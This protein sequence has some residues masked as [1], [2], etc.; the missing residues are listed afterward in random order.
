MRLLITTDTVGGVWT[1]TKEL[2][3]GL[4]LHGHDVLL[5]SMGRLPSSGQQSWVDSASSRWPLSFSYLAT[6]FPLEW[7]QCNTACYSAAESLLLEQIEAWAPDVLHLNQ[8]CYGALRTSIPK[9]VV[10]HSDV[11]SWSQA[12]RG[13][14]PA[15]SKWLRHYTRVVNRGLRQASAVVA[16]TRWMLSALRSNFPVPAHLAVIPNGRSIAG[17]GLLHKRKMQAVTIG[18]VW[19]EGKNIGML[20]K[21]L[22][23]VPILVGGELSLEA[24]PAFMSS[25]LQLLGPLSEKEALQLFVTSSIYIATSRYEPFGLAPLEAALSGCAIVAHDIASLREVWGESAYYF[26]SAAELTDLLRWLCSHRN[27]VVQGAAGACARARSLYSRETMVAQY[28]ALYMHLTKP[29]IFSAKNDL[30]A[31]HVS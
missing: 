7:M 14:L 18:R 12:C 24:E 28:L 4:L 3:E 30:V 31:Q 5:I 6:E 9:L 13:T 15:D 10:A 11:L 21:V 17:S 25:R 26:R 29:A 16:P 8:F 20:E 19:D 27:Q 2:S 22:S 1:Y 23:P